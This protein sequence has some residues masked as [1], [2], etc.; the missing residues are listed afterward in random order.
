[1]KCIKNYNGKAQQTK[2]NTLNA[3]NTKITDHQRE[4][5]CYQ[6]DTDLIRSDGGI[7]CEWHTVRK[8]WSY[9]EVHVLR[10]SP[11]SQKRTG[12]GSLD[13][14]G[15]Y[16]WRTSGDCPWHCSCLWLDFLVDL[17]KAQEDAYHTPFFLIICLARK[18]KELNCT[19]DSKHK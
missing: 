3:W 1:M 8:S 13:G 6:N 15:I 17:V 10:S 14:R 5:S 16:C 18:P 2:H 4:I 12:N 19:V 9:G 7:Q 11:K